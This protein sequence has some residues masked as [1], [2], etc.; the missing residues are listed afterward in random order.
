MLVV[1][2]LDHNFNRSDFV[3]GCEPAIKDPAI[4]AKFR[5]SFSLIDFQNLLFSNFFQVKPKVLIL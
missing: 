5:W 4:Q 2:I 1:T 3:E